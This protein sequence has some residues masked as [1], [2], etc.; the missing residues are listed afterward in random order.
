MAWSSDTY[1]RYLVE[2]LAENGKIEWDVRIVEIDQN[3]EEGIGILVMFPTMVPDDV[4][5]FCFFGQCKE[6]L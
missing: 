4:E 1:L 6:P 3:L 2:W 5:R